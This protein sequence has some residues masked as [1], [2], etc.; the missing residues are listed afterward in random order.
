[1]QG[2]YTAQLGLRELLREF[3]EREPLER[4]QGDTNKLGLAACQ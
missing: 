3:A 2:W 4:C 1:M